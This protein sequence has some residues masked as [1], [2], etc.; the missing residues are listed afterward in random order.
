[1]SHAVPVG[2]SHVLLFGVNVLISKIDNDE[3]DDNLAL[4][5]A[6]SNTVK[7]SASSCR[8][9]TDLPI[10]ESCWSSDRKQTYQSPSPVGHQ[11]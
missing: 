6:L 7:F 9:E 2:V 4:Y 10:T 1:M 11:T 8:Q 5:L 3:D